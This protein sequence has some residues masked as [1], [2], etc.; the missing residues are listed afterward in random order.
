VEVRLQLAEQ[1]LDAIDLHGGQRRPGDSLAA[2]HSLFWSC[3][4]LSVGL[5]PLGELDR[6]DP[7]SC[8]RAYLR[9]KRDQSEGPFPTG[10]LCCP[11]VTGTTAPSDFRSAPLA[12]TIGLHEWSVPD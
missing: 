8:P 6:D 1:S 3:R 4:T 11:P 5:S 2:A 12:F 9:C 10:R 7:G